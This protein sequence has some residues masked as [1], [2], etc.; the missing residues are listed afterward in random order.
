MRF[1]YQ[2]RPQA[3]IAAGT[4]ILG[5][6][7]VGYAVLGSSSSGATPQAAGG[8]VLGAVALFLVATAAGLVSFRNRRQWA[9]F[10]D[11]QAQALFKT[12]SRRLAPPF[13][14]AALTLTHTGML[15]GA[16]AVFGTVLAA[17][18]VLSNTNYPLHLSGVAR[19]A[20]D[21]MTPLLGMAGAVAV[22]LVLG[23]RIPVDALVPALVGVWLITF[24]G[25][26]LEE[27]FNAERPIRLAVMGE[28]GL[29]RA[30]RDEMKAAGVRDHVIVGWVSEGCPEA[31]VD[32]AEE[33]ARLGTIHEIRE[34]VIGD[35][36]DLLVMGPQNGTADL[37]EATIESCVDLPVRMMPA[38]RLY[39][40][41][42]GRVPV[43]AI[44]A[45]WFAY[46][47]H[48]RF[49]PQP[50]WSKRL[51]DLV[52]AAAGI[53]LL[54]PLFVVVAA[55]VKLQDGGPILFRQRRVGAQGV[56]FDVLKFRSMRVDAEASGVAQWS[57]EADP[58]VTAL[59]RFLRAAHLDEM[60]QLFNVLGGTMSLVGPRP[61]RPE[62]VSELELKVPYY[63]RRLLVKPGITGW[64]QVRSGYAG[65]DLGT[66]FK[67]CHDLY[68]IKHRS[69]LFDVL[70][71]VETARTLV[72]D[73]QY[74][75]FNFSET[76]IVGA[77]GVS[78]ESALTQTPAV[79]AEPSEIGRRLAASA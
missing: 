10:G 9:S 33:V 59:G 1:L 17:S 2:H 58:R 43:G 52:M 13:T 55:A 18:V 67:L 20:F 78:Q 11:F 25:G 8:L 71:L 73:V 64:A 37:F 75:Q 47:M 30:L 22:G 19:F 3:A 46:L 12:V 62:F 74:G 39:E 29:A 27:V 6:F 15:G 69:M 24:L 4:L 63:S 51:L 31:E 57:T 38:A 54:L 45:G 34:V 36:I 26:W 48:P 66:A 53:L 79:L 76:F 65:S 41:M 70:T 60:P 50:R 56:E 68:Y 35:Q 77:N 5:V 16:T 7:F 40:E 23:V 32:D 61:E 28:P 21:L 44:S 42:H 72:A 14:A 49:S